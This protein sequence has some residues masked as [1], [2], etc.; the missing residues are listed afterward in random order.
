MVFMREV[1]YKRFVVILVQLESLKQRTILVCHAHKPAFAILRYLSE[2]K[3]PH[4]L[5]DNVKFP[6]VQPEVPYRVFGSCVGVCETVKPVPDIA[7]LVPVV[8]KKVMQQCAAYQT[9]LIALYPKSLRKPYAVCR[10][11]QRVSEN[12]YVPVLS[13]PASC[14]V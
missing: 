4:M 10:H 5:A 11:R 7:G 3:R 13:E 6:L 2:R 9:A 8:E 1:L 14:G 12:R